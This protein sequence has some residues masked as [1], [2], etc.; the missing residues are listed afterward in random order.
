MIEGP[1]LI[2][3]HLLAET[4][5]E[6]VVDFVHHN[7]GPTEGSGI[8]AAGCSL[9][10]GL[11]QVLAIVVGGG[12]PPPAK[13][14]LRE[15][16]R[17]PRVGLTL[18]RAQPEGQHLAYLAMGYRYTTDATLRKGRSHTVYALQLCEPLLEHVKLATR[19]TRATLTKLREAAGTGRELA[20][21]LLQASRASAEANAADG[22][23]GGSEETAPSPTETQRAAALIEQLHAHWATLQTLEPTA[24]FEFCRTLYP[25]L[26]LA[27]Q[28]AMQPSS[29]LG[30]TI[31]RF[32]PHAMATLTNGAHAPSMT[33]VTNVTSLTNGPG[34]F[35]PS[36]Y[37][38][39]TMPMTTTMTVQSMA[40]VTQL[41][42]SSAT[43]V[44]LDTSIPL[45]LGRAERVQ[46]DRL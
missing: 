37:P 35:P 12:L 41:Q 26:N 20:E 21:S 19:A 16:L 8:A 14:E 36:G 33:N 24:L 40:S 9:L 46:S 3:N 17:T 2:V 42:T 32:P 6:R 18:K 31:Q 45:P 22:A 44:P 34:S 1:C 7:Y 4:G 10:P 30:S 39:S 23:A 29:N 28:S 27:V 11:P 38:M 5:L 15:V 43:M 25:D 13:R